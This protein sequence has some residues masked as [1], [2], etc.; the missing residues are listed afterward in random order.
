MD[1]A[2]QAYVEGRADASS[3]AAVEQRLAASPEERED[4]ESMRATVSL[5]RLVA[6]AQAPRSFA[7]RAATAQ[8]P[9]VRNTPWRMQAPA[10]GAAAA[11]LVMGVFIAGDLAGALKQSGGRDQS[12]AMPLSSFAAPDRPIQTGAAAMKL[13][14]PIVTEVP[15]GTTSPRT[16]TMGTAA[17]AVSPAPALPAA[18]ALD[19][20]TPSGALAGAA[21]RTSALAPEMASGRDAVASMASTPAPEPAPASTTESQDQTAQG[22]ANYVDTSGQGRTPTGHAE[23]AG[24]SATGGLHLPLWQIEAGLAGTAG[25]LLAAWVWQRRRN[26]A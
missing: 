20:Q 6:P 23:P 2:A 25:V 26:A 12:S 19:P 21:D 10:M 9:T 13:D 3:T 15:V 4:A 24:V 16:T 18:K 11:V 8:R 22:G 14:Q 7:L 17:V 5:L 1:E